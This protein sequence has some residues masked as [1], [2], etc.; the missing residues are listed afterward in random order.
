[1]RILLF[2]SVA[3]KMATKNKFF[4]KFFAYYSQ[5]ARKL[6]APDPD[7]VPAQL[8]FIFQIYVSGELPG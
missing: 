4:I 7:P 5:G 6:T 3:F 8:G 2:S 1:M